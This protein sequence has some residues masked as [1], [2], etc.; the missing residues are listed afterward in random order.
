MVDE[1]AKRLEDVVVG[2]PAD[3]G[4]IVIVD[5]DD[6]WPERFRGESARI[7][8]AL[9]QRVMGLEHVGSTA[10]PGLSA[11]PIVDILLVVGD[12]ADE[13]A[14]L[15]ALERAGYE[16]RVRE[17]DFDEHRLMRTPEKDVHIHVFSLGS[18]EIERLRLFRDHLR[19]HE[20]DRH[21]YSDVKRDLALRTW[22]TMQHYA[23][24][25][26][27]V[28]TQIMARALRQSASS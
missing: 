12:S 28:I 17:P 14:Y 23:E 11:K 22:P 25:K 18:S 5:Y 9:G 24:A 7:R 20:G 10:V 16:L 3:H 26:T 27:D 6:A 1:V 19:R 21:R 2:N 15:P 4:P 8:R 13:A